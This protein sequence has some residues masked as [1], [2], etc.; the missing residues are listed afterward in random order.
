MGRG[1]FWAALV[2]LGAVLPRAGAGEPARPEAARR[3]AALSRLIKKAVVAGL[4]KVMKD[5]SGWGG[6]IPVPE[7]LRAPRLRRTY[8]KVGDHWE[9][10]QGTWRKVRLWLEDPNRDLDVRVREL[11]QVDATHYRLGV[12]A[13]AA[14]RLEADV[15]QW[16]RGLLLLD[17]TAQADADVGLALDFNVRVELAGKLPPEV[18]VA[19]RVTDL[20]MELKDFT[21]RRVKFHRAGVAVEG[22]AR[23]S[24]EL[25]GVLQ[26]LLRSAEPRVRARANAAIA[27]ALREGRGT[28]SAADLLKAVPTGGAKD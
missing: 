27:R 19:P 8:V 23:L 24:D 25:K 16:L 10:P 1:R 15:R 7:R 21:L 13:D 12:D 5:D 3:Y 20:K 28:L 26:G 17:A 11:R 9:L 4:P 2:V 6:T 14:L 18:K 22:D